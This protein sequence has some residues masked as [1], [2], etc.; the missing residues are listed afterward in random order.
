MSCENVGSR[1]LMV[2]S[3]ACSAQ[4]ISFTSMKSSV[5][6]IIHTQVLLRDSDKIRSDGR[7]W[8]V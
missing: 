1:Q 8:Y 2:L 6:I 4:D 7:P 3:V 5:L